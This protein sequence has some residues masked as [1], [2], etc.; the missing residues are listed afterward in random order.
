M[1][2]SLQIL[3]FAQ[4][5]D[6]RWLMSKEV[7]SARRYFRS[8]CDMCGE[9][10]A[11]STAPHVKERSEVWIVLASRRRQRSRRLG[12]I[13]GWEALSVVAILAILCNQ[14]GGEAHC[15]AVRVKMIPSSGACRDYG[16]SFSFMMSV[17]STL[18]SRVADR[19]ATSV[20]VVVHVSTA[21]S[22]SAA[23]H[24]YH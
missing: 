12:P 1:T 22:A 16:Q 23:P 6:S 2:I 21:T 11:S 3:N 9:L 5:G 24:R 10:L 18:S 20:G 19:P 4:G 17:P 8:D 13:T 7:G 15:A 14:L